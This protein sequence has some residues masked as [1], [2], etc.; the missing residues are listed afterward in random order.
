MIE[1]IGSSATCDTATPTETDTPGTPYGRRSRAPTATR[2]RS[3]D[4]EG[5]AQGRVAQEDRELLAAEAGRHVVVA[6]R[7]G[8]GA[9]D[10]AQDL[11]ADG[12]AEPVVDPLEVV[13]VDHQDAE[14][15][16][17]PR[18]RASSPQNSSK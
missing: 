4:L 12:V 5:A 16:V 10:G 3:R 9:G 17:G 13:D 14:R 2:T 6:D 11:V 15:V 1:S 7:P 8:H 18:R